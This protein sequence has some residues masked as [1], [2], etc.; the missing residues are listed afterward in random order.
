MKNA[1]LHFLIGVV[2]LIM[3][4][5]EETLEKPENYIIEFGTACGWCGGT[6]FIL[7]NSS[8]IEYEKKIPCGSEKGETKKERQI[9]SE[10]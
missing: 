4:C 2:L 8:K 1:A 5:S 7:I 6:E 9:S 10:E 3:A